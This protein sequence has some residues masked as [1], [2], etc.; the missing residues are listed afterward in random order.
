MFRPDLHS[1]LYNDQYGQPATGSIK[2]LDM[3]YLFLEK[4]IGR[5]AGVE[6]DNGGSDP[7]GG[8]VESQPDSRLLS[9]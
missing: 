6:R 3:L 7:A 1:R 4:V 8:K 2:P 5:S 9:N